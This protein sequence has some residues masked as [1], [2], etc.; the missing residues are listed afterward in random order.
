MGPTSSSPTS[1]TSPTATT[2]TTGL[3]IFK[4]TSFELI[5]EVASVQIGCEY[6]DETY[7]SNYYS[8]L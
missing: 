3:K 8:R 2:T 4:V 5:R 6:Y 7:A 1:L